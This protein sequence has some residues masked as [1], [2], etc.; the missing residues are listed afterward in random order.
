MDNLTALG[1]V[2]NPNGLMSADDLNGV[3]GAPSTNGHKLQRKDLTGID[4]LVVGAGIGGLNAAIELYRQGH[5]VRIVEA[6]EEIKSLVGKSHYIL[7]PAS[8]YTL[9]PN[10]R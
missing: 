2:L 10:T 5:E 4:V 7:S 1:A 8:K 9:T 6:K 3:N